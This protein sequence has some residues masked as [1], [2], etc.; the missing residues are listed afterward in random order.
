MV[1]FNFSGTC[2]GAMSMNQFDQVT[3]VSVSYQATQIGTHRTHIAITALTFGDV[4]DGV[5]AQCAHILVCLIRYSSIYQNH[6]VDGAI[7]VTEKSEIASLMIHLHVLERYIMAVKVAT[8]GAF[9]VTNG[10]PVGI[11]TG[12]KI[13]NGVMQPE[14]GLITASR[15][16][17]ITQFTCM[18]HCGER[19]ICEFVI[20]DLVAVDGIPEGVQLCHT[21]DNKRVV[22][23][24]QEKTHLLVTHS[25]E[26]ILQGGNTDVAVQIDT[27]GQ[28]VHATAGDFTPCYLVILTYGKVVCHIHHCFIQSQQ[29]RCHRSDGGICTGKM[30]QL[31]IEPLFKFIISKRITTICSINQTLVRITIKP[32]TQHF[33]CL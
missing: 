18:I 14:V 5:T 9:G 21:F 15:N 13:E 7:V 1:L 17:Q 25:M 32:I 6:T 31:R 26:R 4:S 24:H 28:H 27:V 20:E 33:R 16:L 8:E 12:C 10:R 29:H 23:R 30:L 11:S 22:R 3:T 19:R 2:Y